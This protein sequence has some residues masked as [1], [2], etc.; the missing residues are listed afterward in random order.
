MTVSSKSDS[1]RIVMCEGRSPRGVSRPRARVDNNAD[2]PRGTNRGFI[3]I[4]R[5]LLLCSSVP[6]TRRLWRPTGPSQARR[7]AGSVRPGRRASIFCADIGLV[8]HAPPPT[9]AVGYNGSDVVR[10]SRR[11]HHRLVRLLVRGFQP[12]THHDHLVTGV[13]TVLSIEL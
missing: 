4:K 2:D 3:C 10:R 1:M 12:V 13:E 11:L 7:L 9:S 6:P 5:P 8:K